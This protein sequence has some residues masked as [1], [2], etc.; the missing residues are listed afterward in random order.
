MK[1]VED[2]AL[3]KAEKR[4]ARLIVTLADGERLIA[5]I[6]AMAGDPGLGLDTAAVMAKCQR[7]AA[8][9]IGADAMALLAQI[10][11]GASVERPTP[12]FAALPLGMNAP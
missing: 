4:G 7:F 1:L 3:T 6:G 12:I 10:M 2:P 5:S 11:L 8:P 9:V